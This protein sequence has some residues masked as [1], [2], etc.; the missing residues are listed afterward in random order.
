MKEEI[1]AG[2]KNAV[3]RGTSI[4]QAIQSFINAGYNAAE[5]NEAA[6][7]VS[8]GAMTIIN[9]PNQKQPKLSLPATPAGQPIPAVKPIL[10]TTDTPGVLPSKPVVG[11]NFPVEP[12]QPQRLEVQPVKKGTSTGL[13]ITLVIILLI[14]IAGLISTLMFKEQILN[15]F[16]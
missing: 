11:T 14:L 10:Q 8:S 6:L 13:V 7:L 3:E 1:A 4:D 12:R 15:M 16:G 2:L 9:N 5:V